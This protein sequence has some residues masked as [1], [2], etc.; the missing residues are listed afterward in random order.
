[1]RNACILHGKLEKQMRPLAR[2]VWEDSL[3]RDLIEVD[4]GD[5]Q[6]IEMVQDKNRG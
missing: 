1:M 3:I 6:W 4:Y 5:V 2:R